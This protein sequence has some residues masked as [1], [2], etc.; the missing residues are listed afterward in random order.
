M[1]TTDWQKSTY[2]GDG[3]NCLYV[4][5]TSPGTIHLRESDKPEV[6]LITTRP[7][8]GDTDTSPEDPTMPT[9]YVNDWKVWDTRTPPLVSQTFRLPMVAAAGVSHETHGWHLSAPRVELISMSSQTPSAFFS[10]RAA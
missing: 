4:A 3:S 8:L 10:T 1:H 2:S 5:A 9:C 6:I 7:R